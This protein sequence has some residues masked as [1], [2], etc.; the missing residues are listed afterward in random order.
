[1]NDKN[2]CLGSLKIKDCNSLTFIV[3][4]QLPS[5]LK[6]LEIES[7]EKLEYLW[8]DRDE[9]CTSVVDE[10]NSNNKRTSLLKYLLVKKC[11]SLKCLSSSGQLP[12]KIRTI[13][14]YSLPELESIAKSFHNTRSLEEMFISS[15][16]N[17]KSISEG[18]HNLN[19]LRRIVIDGCE[20]IDCFAEEGL[21]N[22]NLSELTI[23]YCKKLKVL[24]NR[25]HSVKSLKSLTLCG[26]QSMRGFP[27]EG[28]PTSLTSLKIIGEVKINK[29][30]LEWG[31]HN[32]T[33]LTYLSIWGV[34]EE[35]FPQQEMEMTFPPSLTH[36][37][38]YRFPNLKCLMGE[39][40]RNLNS[41]EKLSINGSPNLTSFPELSLPSSLSTLWIWH[42]PE[43]R[44]FPE[45]GL[46]SS[47]LNL[48][49]RKCPKLKEECKRDKGKEWSKIS[50]I[51]C[52][53]IDWKFVYDPEEEE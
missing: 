10:E 30:L 5:S 8:D 23:K 42:C 33:S 4:G 24:P 12:S 14:L 13:S 18:L 50:H 1:M 37:S 49:I 31:L 15:C 32:L 43:V 29:P 22:T 52:V 44:S 53:K 45:Q 51:P 11:L 9:S 40:F 7:C 35:S 34:P 6:R 20:S 28:F 2:S 16:K 26:C 36:L 46:P 41:L 19:H 17:L 25:F 48:D 38:I 3:R 39:G 47:L 27:E 21:P